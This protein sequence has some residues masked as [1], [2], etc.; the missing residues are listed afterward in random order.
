MKS[1]NKSILLLLFVFTTGSMF[2]QSGAEKAGN[3]ALADF[4]FNRAI[5][6]F[7]RV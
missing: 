7:Q 3:R 2:A 1:I 6:I 4:R 5:E